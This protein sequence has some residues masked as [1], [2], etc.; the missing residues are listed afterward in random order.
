LFNSKGSSA[1]STVSDTRAGFNDFIR[2]KKIFEPIKSEIDDYLADALDET[3][4]DD[5]FDILAWWKLKASKY[6]VLVR[7]TRDILVVPIFT[8]T[9]ESTFSTSGRTLN[10]VRDSLSNESIE[11]LVCG[12]DWLRASVTGMCCLLYVI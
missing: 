10:P 5:D 8:V 3:S 11:S 9:S 7:L 6:P 12:Q 4:F 2:V 1:S